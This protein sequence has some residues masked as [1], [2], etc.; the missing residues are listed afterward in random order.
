MKCIIKAM[1]EIEYKPRKRWWGYISEDNGFRYLCRYNHIIAV[2]S[3]QDLLMHLSEKDLKVTDK[4]GLL[5]AI[6]YFNKNLKNG[7]VV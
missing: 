5:F 6:N 1:N 3:D 7:N 2:F 4:R